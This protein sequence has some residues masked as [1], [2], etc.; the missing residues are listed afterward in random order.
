MILIDLTGKFIIDAFGAM[1]HERDIKR[2]DP[3]K[4]VGLRMSS[5]FHLTK[6]AT[7]SRDGRT[8]H[9]RL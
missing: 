5:A 9:L 6:Q 8:L 7:H 4:Q 3:N 2:Y 1:G